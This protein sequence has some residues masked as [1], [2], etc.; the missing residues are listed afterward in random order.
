MGRRRYLFPANLMMGV[1]VLWS[2]TLRAEELPLWP[3]PEGFR[4]ASIGDDLR[5]NGVPVRVA[6][7]S[8]IANERDFRRDMERECRQRRGVFQALPDGLRQLWSC[9]RE[10]Y[11]QTLRWQA[12]GGRIEGELSTIRLNASVKKSPLPVALPQDAQV[13]SDLESRDG[14]T[15]GR[16][17]LVE[18]RLSVPQLRA[19]LLRNAASQGW[20]T[21]GD[22]SDQRE[23]LSLRKPG[24]SLDLAFPSDHPKDT[25]VVL[26]W[27]NH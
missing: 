19:D 17:I 6:L 10:P 9:V 20:K 24:A 21:V 25:M 7:F 18:S 1:I 3:L 5:L 4:T 16:V 22:L 13:I 27:Q 8:G 2:G 14:S 11:S 12:R 26:V 15:R 23:R